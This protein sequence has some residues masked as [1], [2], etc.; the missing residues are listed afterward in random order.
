MDHFL[1]PWVVLI[2]SF[3]SAFHTLAHHREP[4]S[5]YSVL[6]RHGITVF[7]K[8]LQFSLKLGTDIRVETGC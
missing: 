1:K 3:L 7:I 2:D 5:W 8:K 4:V 6:D